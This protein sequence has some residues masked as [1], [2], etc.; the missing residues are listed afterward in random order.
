[1]LREIVLDTETTGLDPNSGHRIIEIGAVELFDHVPTGNV[2]HRYINPE[3]NI[4]PETV[5]IHNITDEF[6]K[7]K[8]IFKDIIQELIVFI[9]D[10]QLIIHN[11]EFDLKFIKS[12]FLIAEIEPL[13]WRFIDTI[14]L[15]REKFPG[16]SVS[17]DALCKRFNIDT[18]DRKY[19]GHGALI[20]SMLLSE[21]YLELCGGKQ[22]DFGFKEKIDRKS[23]KNSQAYFNQRKINL[24]P[25]LS[26]DDIKLHKKFVQ[27]NGCNRFWKRFYVD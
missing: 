8:P 9:Q 19:N 11:A 13:D 7:D 14:I 24:P 20:D 1:M 3:R 15:A 2:F 4:P 10:S 22:P 5:R 25:R 27:S 26:S 16:S 6:V 18:S 23:N 12:E 21:V 17:L